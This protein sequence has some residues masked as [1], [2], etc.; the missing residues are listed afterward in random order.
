MLFIEVVEE[1]V[2]DGVLDAVLD[3]FNEGDQDEDRDDVLAMDVTTTEDDVATTGDEVVAGEPIPIQ[4]VG[5]E[6]VSD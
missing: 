1:G 4:S 6:M 5:R 3:G 2:L